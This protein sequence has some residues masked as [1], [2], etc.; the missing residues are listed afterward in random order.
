MTVGM[1]NTQ[2]TNYAA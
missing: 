2:Q 1:E